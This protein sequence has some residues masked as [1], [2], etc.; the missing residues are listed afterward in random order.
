MALRGDI[1]AIIRSR[2][3]AHD[4][5]ES[6]IS[7]VQDR[8]DQ[9][10]DVARDRGYTPDEQ[11]ELDTLKTAHAEV[12]DTDRHIQ[13][14]TVSA[15]ENSQALKSLIEKID[16]NNRDLKAA[17]D[18]IQ[19]AAQAIKNIGDVLSKVSSLLG[20]LTALLALPA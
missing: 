19:S 12:L 3:E 5:L 17:F 15:L 11:N 10:V 14:V 20:G 4:A 8:I 16:R 9:I 2:D 18:D 6:K 7:D 13:L 1:D